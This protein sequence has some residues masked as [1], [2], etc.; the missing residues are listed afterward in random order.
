MK[1]T[2]GCWARPQ[3]AVIPGGPRR[4]RH[5]AVWALAARR[6][7]TIA[8]VMMMTTAVATL[9]TSPTNL[10]MPAPMRRGRQAAIVMPALP[11]VA[12]AGATAG[13][14]PGLVVAEANPP[15]GLRSLI[16]AKAATG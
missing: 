13:A 6:T 16:K 9:T 1:E 11:V 15:T 7:R 12:M 10:A 14:A 3:A 5:A 8:K 4:V 2:F